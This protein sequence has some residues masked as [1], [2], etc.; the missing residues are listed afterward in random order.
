MFLSKNTK[1][2]LAIIAGILIACGA[3]FGFYNS[4]YAGKVL[5]GVSAAGV[6]VSGLSEAEAKTAL[7]EQIDSFNNEEIAL[8]SEKETF[9]AKPTD[10]GVSID[11][12]KTIGKAHAIGRDASWYQNFWNK[13]KTVFQN[14]Y[15]DAV[16]EIDKK[17]F[18]EY[19]SG[20]FTSLETPARNASLK[21]ENG[22]VQ[23]IEGKTGI[24]ADRQM[25]LE[26]L[27]KIASHLQVSDI[28]T[29]FTTA[30]P[31]ID[32][33]DTA[34]AKLAAV[35]LLK[36]G[37]ILKY[38][39]ESWNFSRDNTE[40]AIEFIPRSKSGRKVSE[41]EAY[42]YGEEDDNPDVILGVDLT[43]DQ[44]TE[45]INSLASEINREPKNAYF[46]IEDEDTLEVSLSDT[47][48][49]ETIRDIEVEA[50]AED[51]LEFNLDKTEEEI[52]SEI[53]EGNPEI[54]VTANIID[55]MVT[56]ENYEELGIKQLISR[57]TSNF[58]GSPK[59][60]V[61]NIGVG[62][63]RFDSSLI[64]PG[65]TFSFN[66]V[67]GPVDS[68]TGY[69]PELV[70][71]ENDTIPEMGGGLCQVS[72]TNFRAVIDAG[73]PV[74]ERK[75][76]AYAVQYY[77]PQGTDATIYPGSS[78]FRFTN[79]TPGH[80]LI[81]TKIIGKQLI[82]D[83]FGTFDDREVEKTKPKVYERFGAGGVKAEWSYKVLFDGVV[84]TEDTFKSVYRPPIEFH[85]DMRDAK[86][87]DEKKKQEEE[88][89][90]K[91]EAEAAKKKAEEDAKKKE[92]K[93]KDDKKTD[94]KKKDEKKDDDKD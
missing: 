4:A 64:Q 31:I 67:L 41:E 52:F 55:P 8:I 36:Q 81:Q 61:H 70:I 15:V 83:F 46:T 56:E 90:K 59:N 11:I 22:T 34:A 51:G 73:L 85:K 21:I 27:E 23:E 5:A 82:F 39:E 84:T 80:I 93:P 89:K 86:D 6:D 60:R 48:D 78:D 33:D 58:S 40:A 24:M 53:N 92:V 10:L 35:N 87:E 19:M 7:E 13:T 38:D 76:H 44:Y 28:D 47:K 42:S 68:S 17:A 2:L 12:D 37:L 43:S 1:I 77:A 50:N 32:V 57:G 3:F 49:K 29:P 25:V 62:A 94:D 18:N 88:E 14:N 9:R 69:L 65:A 63:S 75:N 66:E 16:Y 72:T 30:Y 20:N 45:F 71:K 26:Q 79:D 91:Q 54:G 74:V